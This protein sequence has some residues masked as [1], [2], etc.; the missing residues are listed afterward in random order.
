[1][2]KE[3]FGVHLVIE[4]LEVVFILDSR[5][6]PIG[7]HHLQF[8]SVS[9]IEATMPET[10]RF[11]TVE[12]S[13]HR[14]NGSHYPEILL[15]SHSTSWRFLEPPAKEHLGSWSPAAPSPP[16]ITALQAA[17]PGLWTCFIK[18]QVLDLY[19]ES[20]LALV[21]SHIERM[22]S[23]FPPS[24]PPSSPPSANPFS[25]LF[26]TVVDPSFI[27]PLFPI[28]S[29][30]LLPSLLHRRRPSLTSPPSLHHRPPLLLFPLIC[31][32]L[33]V[34]PPLPRTPLSHQSLSP[35]R[36]LFPLILPPPFCPQKSHRTFLYLPSRPS[37]S[38]PPLISSFPPP[39]LHAATSSLLFHHRPFSLPAIPPRPLNSRY[40]VQF[41]SPR[42]SLSPSSIL[43]PSLEEFPG[44]RRS[45]GP[46]AVSPLPLQRETSPPVAR[47]TKEKERRG[48]GF[49]L[50]S[51]KIIESRPTPGSGGPICCTAKCSRQPGAGF[52]KQARSGFDFLIGLQSW[53]NRLLPRQS[54]WKS[55]SPTPATGSE[56]SSSPSL[57]D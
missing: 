56:R 35:T 7:C 22:H 53:W 8:S 34:L 43:S 54:R 42:P 17:S 9:V 12:Q 13:L 37:L 57:L 39:S 45:L 36:N 5:P 31:P 26:F 46:W 41:F 15:D 4:K 55:H 27:S 6:P 2:L 47:I 40:I 1:M 10:V 44:L 16:N 38:R 21:L 33:F 52:C 18:K 49:I 24:P 11:T 19:I 29:D 51:R 32:S 20:T 3:P 14:M 48:L 25:P 28:A 23:E 30:P 50:P